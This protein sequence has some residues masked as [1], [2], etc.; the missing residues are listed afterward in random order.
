MT[1]TV[2]IELNS[3][4]AV[5]LVNYLETLPFARVE[6]NRPAPPCAYTVAEARQRAQQAV[7]EIRAGQFHTTEEVFKPYRQWL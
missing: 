5:S 4:Q 6:K 1:A 3:P 7:E 2:T